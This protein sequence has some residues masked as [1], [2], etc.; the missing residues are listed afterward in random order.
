MNDWRHLIAPNTPVWAGV[1]GYADE[2]IAQLTAV[3]VNPATT[4]IEIRQAQKAIEELQRLKGLPDT[5]R[6]SAEI[7]KAPVK[8]RGEY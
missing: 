6:A 2:R 5:L 7:N 4:D 8:R 3:C 1:V